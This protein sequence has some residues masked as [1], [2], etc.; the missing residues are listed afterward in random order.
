MA[1]AV[2]IAAAALC[3]VAVA[4]VVL[5][6][7]AANRGGPAPGPGAPGPAASADAVGWAQTQLRAT[8]GGWTPAAFPSRVD[9]ATGRW[10]TVPS[11]DW[12]SGYLAGCAWRLLALTGGAEWRDRAMQ[13]TTALQ[14]QATGADSANSQGIVLVTFGEA[15]SLGRTDKYVTD[16][17]V[18]SGTTYLK[19]WLPKAN[20]F[21][22][23]KDMGTYPSS[24]II[25][26]M[27]GMRLLWL[28]AKLSG[29]K[30]LDQR[31][32]AHADTVMKWHIRA[33]GSTFH[34]A[35]FAK[36]A[37]KPT[38][39]THQGLSDSSTWARG[40]AWALFGFA[41]MA[42]MTGEARYRDA[43]A[44]VADFWRSRVAD[45]AVPN[46]DLDPA[47]PAHPDTSAAAIAACGLY[48]LAKA[49]GDAK[50]R[51]A[52]DALAKT[53]AGSYLTRG[54]AG[55]QGGP[56]VLCCATLNAG[57]RAPKDPKDRPETWV[58]TGTIMGDY[59]FLLMLSFAAGK[60]R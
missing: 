35:D 58:D 8:F 9:P 32:R 27:F 48:T 11:T 39:R 6:V 54:K 17:I 1:G 56:S 3:C 59:Y 2:L 53:L 47:A 55:R 13:A 30:L 42:D 57:A 41:D 26:S 33:D 37:S 23:W 34:V 12:T 21:Q 24:V 29:N 43:A 31:M 28:A 18:Q 49:G 36:N 4:A 25:D 20:A 19:R 5:I 14:S 50:Y 60:F 16:A 22:S 44:R 46:W 10:I 38:M 52:A 7:L 51:A 15:Y 40:Q 45:G